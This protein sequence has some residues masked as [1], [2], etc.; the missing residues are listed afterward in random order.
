MSQPKSERFRRI[1]EAA[2]NRDGSS[3]TDTMIVNS[4]LAQM[5]MFMMRQGL[6]F[7][8]A[9]DTFGV[10]K[11][12]LAQ[13][14]LENEI[15]ARLEG[16]IDDF[17]IDGK[18]LWYFRPV[19]DSYRLLWFSKDNYRAYYD[20]AGD[21]EEV[22]LIYSFSV[23]DG[24]SVPGTSSCVCGAIPSRSPSLPRSRRLTPTLAS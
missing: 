8:P 12:F 6:E 4:H 13:L 22:E 21:L 18:G 23:R 1:L 14:V 3:G 17:L 9:Q 20:T 16:I 11:S 5:R 10:R 7:Y 24:L 15:D 2:R 19:G